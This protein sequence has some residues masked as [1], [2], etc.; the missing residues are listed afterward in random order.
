VVLSP[1]GSVEAGATM[2]TS[3]AA[4]RLSAVG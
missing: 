2:A 3:T 1:G 4:P